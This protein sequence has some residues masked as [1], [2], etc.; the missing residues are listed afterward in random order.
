MRLPL[1]LLCGSGGGLE[2]GILGQ[3]LSRFLG[4][5]S[6]IFNEVKNTVKDYGAS[7]HGIRQIYGLCA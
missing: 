6:L 3:F 4:S 1:T 5:I 7:W 2:K